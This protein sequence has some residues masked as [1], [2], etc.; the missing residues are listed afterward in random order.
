MT[1]TACNEG[2]SPFFTFPYPRISSFYVFSVFFAWHISS[3]HF[4]LSRRLLQPYVDRSHSCAG[5]LPSPF[6]C[7]VIPEVVLGARADNTTL[8]YLSGF[9]R[10]RSWAS[11][12]SEITVLPAAP[13]YVTLYL[14]SVL[15]AS[16]SSSSV[17]SALYSIRWARD[18]AGL[19]S[20]TNH[21]LP[22]KVLESARRRLSHQ[23]SKNCL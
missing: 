12:F 15:Q 7:Q 19:Q 9:K 20:P 13:A 11:K 14:L 18:F 8:T 4:V 21:T 22:Q 10:W 6:G 2:R 17:Q 16:T 1:T 3:F 23:T 5:P